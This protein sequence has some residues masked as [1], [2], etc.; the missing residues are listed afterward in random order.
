MSVLSEPHGSRAR[1][2]YIRRPY[3]VHATLRPPIIDTGRAAFLAVHLLPRVCGEEP[4]EQLRTTN[5]KRILETLVRP[6]DDNHQAIQ[7]TR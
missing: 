5:A 7:Q 3:I 6:S 1:W 4:L 2:K